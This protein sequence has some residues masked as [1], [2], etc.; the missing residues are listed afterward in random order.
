MNYQNVN[1]LQI[2]LFNY[3]R[4]SHSYRLFLYLKHIYLASMLHNTLFSLHCK[5][6]QNRAQHLQQPAGEN[7][8]SEQ[9]RVGW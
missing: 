1:K 9:R 2:Y 4:F 6:N 5:Q 7:I 3:T 8:L